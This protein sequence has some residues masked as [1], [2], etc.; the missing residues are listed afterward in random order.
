MLEQKLN[1]KWAMEKKEPKNR[2]K[3]FF[4]DYDEAYKRLRKP[5]DKHYKDY[6]ELY[7]KF[8]EYMKRE[9]IELK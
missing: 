7:F 1:L 2:V 9:D 8:V 6:K 3:D 5:S 4:R